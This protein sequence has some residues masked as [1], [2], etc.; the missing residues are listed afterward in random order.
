MLRKFA[1]IEVS[2]GLSFSLHGITQ[3]QLEDVRV[4]LSLGYLQTS[5]EQTKVCLQAFTETELDKVFS[6]RQPRQVINKLQSFGDQLH[7][8]R[9]G[10]AI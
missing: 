9:Q 7:L 3:Y 1:K 10:K 5:V 8:H 2:P 6:G 4:S